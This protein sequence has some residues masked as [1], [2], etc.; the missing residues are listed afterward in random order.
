MRMNPLYWFARLYWFLRIWFSTR[1]LK[2]TIQLHVRARAHDS[3]GK[4]IYNT[5]WKPSRSFVIQ[6]LEILWV[7]FPSG[8]QNITTID[9]VEDSWSGSVIPYAT[10][11]A[12]D[13]NRGIVIG[14]GHVAPTNTDYKLGTLVAHGVG[15][16][17]IQYGITSFNQP[18]E[19]AGNVDF[20]ITRVFTNASGGAIAME[21][22]GMYVDES[23]TT[24]YRMIIRDLLSVSIAHTTSITVEYRLRTTV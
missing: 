10:G 11:G 16:N 17:Q 2:T 22:V 7:V 21:E 14:T 3:S 5:G 19:L 13:A 4:E 18:V 23:T 20:V 6:F 24:K 9:N 1:I 12:G 15:A 8:L